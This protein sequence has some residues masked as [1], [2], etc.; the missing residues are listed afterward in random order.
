M[1]YDIPKQFIPIGGKPILIHTFEAFLRY[2]QDLIFILVLPESEIDSWKE[3]CSKYSFTT[4]HIIREGGKTRFQSVKSG[5]EVINDDGLVAIHDGVRPFV[6]ME[7]IESSF[8]VAETNGSAIATVSVRDS[9]RKHEGD[10]SVPVNRDE[11]VV[12]QTPQTFWVD[13]IKSA[14][15][16]D[17]TSA[18]T[19]DASVYEKK[20]GEVTLIEGSYRNIKITSPEDL[21]LA[22]GLVERK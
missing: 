11:F 6:P 8:R 9:I 14:Y 7:V 19:D 4:P 16:C 18:F 13:K 15:D 22:E 21:Q 1:G 12:V 5:L 3:I 17:E 2:S 10:N 20:I